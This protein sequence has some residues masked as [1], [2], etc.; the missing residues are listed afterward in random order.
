[1]EWKGPA[2]MRDLLLSI[3]YEIPYGTPYEISYEILY[4][5]C[6]PERS[7][8]PAFCVAVISRILRLTRSQSPRSLGFRNKSSYLPAT[9]YHTK[10][11][12]TPL[13]SVTHQSINAARIH[14][15]QF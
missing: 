6:H 14:R 10:Y 4:E 13:S 1:M 12:P 11:V 3:S 2:L 15:F 8:G 9:P 5:V 7:E